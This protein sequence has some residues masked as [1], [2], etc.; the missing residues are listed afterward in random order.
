MFFKVLLFSALRRFSTPLLLLQFY[1]CFFFLVALASS[2]T[3]IQNRFQFKELYLSQVTTWVM[4]LSKHTLVHFESKCI[5]QQRCV[6]DAL[7]YRET[8]TVLQNWNVFLA[9]CIFSHNLLLQTFQHIELT[10]WS[11][12]TIAISI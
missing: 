8:N 5:S 1:S 6:V 2:T 12:K 7:S 3:F 9:T 10:L 4:W 11:Q